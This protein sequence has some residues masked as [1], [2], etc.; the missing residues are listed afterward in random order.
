[1][2]SPDSKLT[3]WTA[4][5]FALTALLASCARAPRTEE[6]PA[7]AKET[8]PVTTPSP[9][10]RDALKARLTP[11][12]WKVTQES[13]TERAFSGEYWDNH[14]EG[15]Y[16]DIVDGTPLFSSKDKFDSG[17]GWPSFTQPLEE[18]PL[19][20]KR[21]LTHGMIRTEVRSAR[22]DS[23]LGHVFDDGPQPTGLRYCINSASLRFVPVAD[24]EK[25]GLGRFLPLFGK[26]PSGSASPAAAPASSTETAV[27]AGGCFWGMEDLLRKIPGVL[28]TEC[29]YTG[30]HLENPKYDDTHDSKSGH[31]ESVKIVFDPAKVSYDELLVWFFK[32]HDPTTLNRQGNDRGTQYRSTIFYANAEQKAAA[33]K[34]IAEAEKKWKKKVVTTLE[35]AAKWWPAE[36]Y[37]QDYLVKNPRGYTCHYIRDL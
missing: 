19:V 27:L 28:D 13:G 7:P 29:G 31:A 8:A 14:A 35:P 1:M 9:I 10:D 37:H 23:H 11:M 20:E 36:A 2:T 18:S 26:A 33:E 17:C 4:L 34:A 6:A 3:L 15:V 21:D 5:L 32:I 12:Q 16:V 24:L 25:E 30:G 22:A